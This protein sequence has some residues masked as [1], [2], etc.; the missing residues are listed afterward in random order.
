MFP[1]PPTKTLLLTY[2]A[3]SVSKGNGSIVPILM[4]QFT[5]ESFRTK[6]ETEKV[7]I[8]LILMIYTM[9]IGWRT[10]CMAL[11]FISSNQGNLT[12]A[13]WKKG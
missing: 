7:Y 13:S 12:K 6:K 5:G 1:N 3:K 10:Q 4:D 8:F 11:E 9:G 2:S